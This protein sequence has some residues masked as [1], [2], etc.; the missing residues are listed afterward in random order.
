MVTLAA[1]AGMTEQELLV[2]AQVAR[3][4]RAS[5]YDPKSKE[6]ILWTPSM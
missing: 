5:D 6:V 1:K 4:C 3:I 2:Q